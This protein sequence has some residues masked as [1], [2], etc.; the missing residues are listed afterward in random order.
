MNFDT[1]NCD[2]ALIGCGYWGTNIAKVLT[3]IKKNKI[4]VFDENHLN[5][6]ILKKRFPNNIIISKKLDYILKSNK[7]K[8]TILA[9]PPEQN[10][11]L[12]KFCIENKKNI[13]IEKPGLK[14][15]SD[16][17]KIKKMIQTFSIKDIVTL[18]SK[19]KKI[20]KKDIYNYCLKIRNEK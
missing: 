8:N 12:L 14:K 20:S 16:L 15:Y 7:I 19:Q 9:T 13:F 11:K 17:I 18:I 10:L 6:I 2:T 3:K 5:S 1:I 4:I